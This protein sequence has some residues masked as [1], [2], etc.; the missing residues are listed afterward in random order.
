[1]EDKWDFNWQVIRSGWLF[2][3]NVDR[4]TDGTPKDYINKRKSEALGMIVTKYYEMFK[5]YGGLPWID[6]YLR[7]GDFPPPVRLSVTATC[8]SICHLIDRAMEYLP[9]RNEPGEFGRI[10]RI[11]MMML[12]ARTLLVSASPL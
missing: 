7:V 12:K 2:Y 8:D 5:R 11:A 4:V 6:H 1:M 9:D 3:D 10:N